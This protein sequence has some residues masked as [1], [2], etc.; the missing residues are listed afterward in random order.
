MGPVFVLEVPAS[1]F[2]FPL[3]SLHTL[4]YHRYLDFCTSE[5]IW[6]NVLKSGALTTII[7]TVILFPA[8]IWITFSVLHNRLPKVFTRLGVGVVISLLGVASL[9]IIDV[10]GHS[11]TNNIVNHT[12]CMFQITVYDNNTLLY[13]ALNMHW[14]VLIPPSFLLNF[15]PLLVIT[16]TLEFISAQSPQSMKG[17]LV[18]VFFAIRGLFQFF[19]SILIIPFSLKHPWASG[20]MI[21]NP[22]VVNCGFAYLVLTCIVGLIG[23]FLFLVAAKR[24]KYRERNEGMF[25]QH[26]VEEIYERYITQAAVDTFSDDDS[27]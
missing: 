13:P 12:Q 17:L 6:E 20:R 22:P 16:T 24:Y 1:F 26:D 5:I 23:F 10:V 11:L 27:N 19:N 9:S 7:S 8:H 15:G 18:G 2:V 3:F 21:E 25:R 14:A 4:H